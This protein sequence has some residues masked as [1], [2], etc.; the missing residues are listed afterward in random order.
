MGAVVPVSTAL[1]AAG[2]LARGLQGRASARS[3]A[4]QSERDAALLQ[5]QAEEIQAARLDELRRTLSAFRA[6]RS[7]NN[8]PRS[9][10]TSRAI[11]NDILTTSLRDIRTEVGNVRRQQASLRQSARAQR[12]RGRSSLLTGFINSGPSLLS[13]FGGDDG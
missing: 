13:L 1:T 9:S 7:A 5:T 4:R 12:S 8:T 6:V 10:P 11:R 2:G 3:Q